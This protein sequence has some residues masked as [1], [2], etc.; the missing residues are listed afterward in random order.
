M[1][2]RLSLLGLLWL[3]L[4]AAAPVRLITQLSQ[5]RID[6]NT[7]FRGAEL[8]VFGAIQ[9]PSGQAPDRLR[10]A[11]A[12]IVLGVALRLAIGLTWTPAEPFALFEGA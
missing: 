3:A 1:I 2:A 7:S 9:Y 6:I 4:C 10:L 5:A 11:L 8:L 12:L